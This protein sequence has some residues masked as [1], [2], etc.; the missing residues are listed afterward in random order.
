MVCILTFANS[1]SFANPPV[2][3]IQSCKNM[4]AANNSIVMAELD[5]VGL[6]KT[7]DVNCRDQFE[8]KINGHTY[9]WL[10]CDKKPYLIVADKRISLE[11]STNFSVS[12]S[13]KPDTPII[14][15]AL[16]WRIDKADKSY[17][18]IMSPLSENGAAAN[19]FQYFLIED[20]FDVNQKSYDIYFYFFN[21]DF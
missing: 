8:N 7:P 12:P 17:L 11:S 4:T 16:W 18:C 19:A 5:G 10:T 21:K 3:I 13:I 6:N 2:E 14:Q 15:T 1:L 20:A 9:G